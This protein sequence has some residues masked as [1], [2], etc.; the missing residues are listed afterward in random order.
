MTLF[1]TD[2]RL[3]FFRPPSTGR[4]VRLDPLAQLA[5]GEVTYFQVEESRVRSNLAVLVLHTTH[6]RVRLEGQRKHVERFA[7][8]LFA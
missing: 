4:G 6:G 1:L 7:A 3:L 8:S 2:R 5:R